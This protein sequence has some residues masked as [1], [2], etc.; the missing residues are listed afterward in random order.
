MR[1]G[2]AQDIAM[3][4]DL[5]IFLSGKMTGLNKLDMNEWRRE[6]QTK[7]DDDWFG[8][9]KTPHVINPCEHFGNL[10]DKPMWEEPKEYVRWEL[11][12]AREC[13]LLVVAVSRQQ[14]SIGTAC[15]LATAHAFDKPILLYNQY[16]IRHCDIHPFVWEMSDRCFESLDDLIDYIREVYLL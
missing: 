9:S 5:N 8:Y 7:I 15:E 11:R 6:F 2:C 16:G 13:D 10:D 4:S 1:K 12:Q 3:K 14:D